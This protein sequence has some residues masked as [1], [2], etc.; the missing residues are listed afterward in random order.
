MNEDKVI[1]KLTEHDK[2]FD[3][4]DADFKNFKEQVFIAQDEIL[5]ILRRLDEERIFTTAW[6]KENREGGGRTHER[7]RP[8]QDGT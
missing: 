2:R 4:L 7:N 5:S 8:H 3:A 6:G 1:A